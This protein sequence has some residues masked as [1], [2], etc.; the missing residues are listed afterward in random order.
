[1]AVIRPSRLDAKF[2]STYQTWKPLTDYYSY[3]STSRSQGLRICHC[4]AYRS[5]AVCAEKPQTSN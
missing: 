3:Q 4:A 2:C 5:V 1:M